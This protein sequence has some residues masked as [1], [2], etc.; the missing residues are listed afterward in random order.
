[1][2]QFLIYLGTN[3]GV[4]GLAIALPVVWYIQV[5]RP[6]QK[7]RKAE[8][9]RAAAAVNEALARN[10][11]ALTLLHGSHEGLRTAMDELRQGIAE[12]R[13]ELRANHTETERLAQDVDAIKCDVRELKGAL[14]R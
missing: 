4:W 7:D 8:Q 5:Y 3:Y 13:Y 6:D 9:A 12:L 10:T 14:R 2:E 1:V 11:D